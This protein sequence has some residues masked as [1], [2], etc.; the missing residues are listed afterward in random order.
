MTTMTAAMTNAVGG[1]DQDVGGAPFE[2][3]FFVGM[4]L[5]LLTLL[6]NVIGDK[7]VSR[8]RQQY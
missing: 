2:V 4:I 6:L 5:F 1:T 7:F 3:L 8:I